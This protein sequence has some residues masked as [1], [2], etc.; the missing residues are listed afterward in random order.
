MENH[1]SVSMP[2]SAAGYGSDNHYAQYGVALPS[3]QRSMENPGSVQGLSQV[4]GQQTYHELSRTYTSLSTPDSIAQAMS[5]YTNAATSGGA[6]TAPLPEVSEQQIALDKKAI[7]EHPFFPLLDL[8]F[9]KC[10]IAT[11]TSRDANPK[12]DVCSSESFNEDIAVFAKQ[13]RAK[14]PYFTANHELDSLMVQAIQVL[15]F[16]LLEIEKVHE[17][18]NNFCTKYIGCLKGKMPMDLIV[19]EQESEGG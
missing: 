11:S 18:C 9:N 1:H 13:A 19:D 4:Q 17:L 3:S 15:R 7:Y 2:S 6:P 8:I 14:K 12:N 16:H 10:E 5:S